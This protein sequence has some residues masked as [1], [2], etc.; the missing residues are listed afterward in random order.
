[1]DFPL[2]LLVLRLIHT[3]ASFEALDTTAGVYRTLLAGEEWMAEAA[4]FY[5]QL[6]FGG[7]C[8][9]GVAAGAS[10]RGC[11]VLWM[12]IRLHCVRFLTLANGFDMQGD[13]DVI[14]DGG[15]AGLDELVPLHAELL[16]AD[17][18]GCCETS[19][20]TGP[21]IVDVTFELR[22]EDDFPGDIANGK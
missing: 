1:M 21:G 16:A 10:N 9:P 13:L 7:P 8:L 4:Y 6:R 11:H 12:D 5:S 22:V 14:A 15:T 20:A 2:I 18:R 3:V 17:L 19:A